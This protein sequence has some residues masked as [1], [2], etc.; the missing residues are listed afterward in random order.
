VSDQA[1]SLKLVRVKCV[2][3]TGGSFV[4]RFGNDEIW[5]A[6]N[7]VDA[8][9]T[10]HNLPP[11]EVYPHFDDGDIKEFRPPKP[12]FTLA[13]PGGGT[14]PKS[15]FATLLLAEKDSGDLTQLALDA[16]DKATNDMEEMKDEM[17]M[18][19]GDQPPPDFW[20]KAEEKAREWTYGYI[21]DRIA[22]GLNDDVFPAQLVSL[23]I[24]SD[25]FLWGDGTKM[26]PETTVEFRGHGGVYY[27]VYY[28]EIETLAGERPFIFDG[29]V[30]ITPPVG[31]GTFHP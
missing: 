15:C 2:D 9:P 10:T 20:D 17:G 3:E 30:V 7:A 26:S 21:K 6:G 31:G 14:F 13:V 24:T 28:W 16:F 29:D 1:V 5:L 18:G 8:T 12:I 4:E 11:F 23:S 22:A 19:E 27:L 25:D